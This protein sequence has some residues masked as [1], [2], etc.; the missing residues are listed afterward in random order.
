M[1]EIIDSYPF[2]YTEKAEEVIPFAHCSGG[3]PDNAFMQKYASYED[4]HG[5]EKICRQVFLHEDCCRKYQYH[6]M[7]KKYSDLCRRPGSQRYHNCPVFSALHE[8]DLTRY[9]YFISFRSLYVKDHPERMER[10]PEGVGIYPLASEMNMDLLTM[11]VQLLKLKGHTGS[12][13]EHRL[14]N[15][16]QTRMEKHFGSTE[17]ACVIH[18]NA[19][20][21]IQLH[22]LKRLHAHE[23][24]GFTMIWQGKST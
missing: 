2:D 14:H 11:A 7:V 10:L 24:S 18:Y 1:Y 8:L 13:A 17:F 21:P 4:G 9:N 16:L 23:V 20:K 19:T 3:T 15:R 5:A 22:F 6:A 12:W